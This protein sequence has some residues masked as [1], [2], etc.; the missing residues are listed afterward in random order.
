MQGY[1]PGINNGMI[2]G[3]GGSGGSAGGPRFSGNGP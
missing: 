3:G 1:H 2:A